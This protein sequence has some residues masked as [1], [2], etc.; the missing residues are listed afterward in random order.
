LVAIQPG[1]TLVTR[2]IYGVIRHPSYLGFLVGSLGW[3]LA[4]RSGLGVLLTALLIPPLLARIGA[5][6]RL[7]RSQ[8][9]AEY[10]AY[11]S[12]T[13]RLIPGIY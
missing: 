1:H 7:L 12:R 9:G 8:F 6:E 5:E 10:D 2:G 3:V 11:R 4:F 13:S